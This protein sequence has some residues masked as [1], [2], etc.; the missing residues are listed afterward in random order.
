[1]LLPSLL[2]QHLSEW[3]CATKAAAL[4]ARRKFLLGHRLNGGDL[5][6]HEHRVGTDCSGLEAPMVALRQ[7]QF[8][9][10][11]VF[12]SEIAA[13]AREWIQHNFK[14]QVIYE[15]I[16]L[17]NEKNVLAQSSFDGYVAGPP[18]Q[19]WSL[20][21]HRRLGWKDPRAKVFKSTIQTILQGKPRW[22]IIENVV[23]ILNSGSM[24]LKVFQEMSKMY[25]IFAA[26][27]L[28]SFCVFSS[29]WTTNKTF[30]ECVDACCT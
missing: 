25:H 23:A 9:V 10:C 11:H 27:S 21:N 19:P 4:E 18:C 3:G 17:R 26:T 8:R 6:T 13:C 24:V 14:P 7:M 20:L 1:M 5:Q 30:F 16:L 12:S 15:D 29:V 28:F 2:K 22:A